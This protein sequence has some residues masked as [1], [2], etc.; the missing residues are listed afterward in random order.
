VVHLKHIYLMTGL[1]EDVERECSADKR[2]CK[3][4]EIRFVCTADCD[5]KDIIRLRSYSLPDEPN[6]RATICQAAL[7]T[8]AATA[9]FEPVSIGDRTFA[10][11]GLGANN[12]VDEVEGEASNIWCPETRDLKPLVKCFISI[13]TGNPGKKAFED[14]M[15]K[16][17]SQTVVEIATETENT[18]RKF[19]ARWAEHFDEKRYFRFNV[20]QGLQNIGLDEYKKKGA[21]EAATEGHLTHVAQKFRVRD[22][23]RNLRLKQSVYIE[24][25]A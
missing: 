6:I 17:L 7:A 19:I 24:D 9:F 10:D 22:C 23:V 15:I 14:S 25:F 2:R 16:F 13:G 1:S 8:S 12:P 21:M 11:G 3:S 18:E 5:T 4:N 20:D